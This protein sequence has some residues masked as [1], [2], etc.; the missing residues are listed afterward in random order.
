MILIRLL[1]IILL[2]LNLQVTK[3]SKETEIAAAFIQAMQNGESVVAL[4]DPNIYL[5]VSSYQESR[6]EEFTSSRNNI[7]QAV[8]EFSKKYSLV[9]FS[10]YF[11]SNNEKGESNSNFIESDDSQIVLTCMN[12]RVND[13]LENWQLSFLFRNSKVK[14]LI[15]FDF[16][17]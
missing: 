11:S 9:S 1:L 5:S 8:I 7:D 17:C 12:V 15:F 14:Q 4:S 13:K 10:K 2:S 6:E 3:A 16:N